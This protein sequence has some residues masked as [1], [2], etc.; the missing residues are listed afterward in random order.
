M[1]D[2]TVQNSQRF[3]WPVC[4]AF[5]GL[6]VVLLYIRTLSYGFATEPDACSA[7]DAQWPD[8]TAVSRSSEQL[9]LL[10]FV[11]PRCSCT[12]A[13][14]QELS[15]VLSRTKQLPAVRVIASCPR[16]A[17]REW[18]ES[19]IVA[20]A[21]ALPNAALIDD[22]WGA[23]SARFGAVVSGTVIVFSQGGS[24]LFS[25]GVT[26]S[27]GHTG[28]STGGQMLLAVL[29][30]EAARQQ[31]AAPVFGC[32]LCLPTEGRRSPRSVRRSGSPGIPEPAGLSITET[33]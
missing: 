17:T 29:N 33:Q 4:I 30:G 23:E 1:S 7:E 26:S 20:D 18:R 11:H 2:T 21:A 3:V 9:T 15:R 28:V 5:W 8:G 31:A 13:S 25:G 22:A 19:S 6:A 27:R 16:N 24:R 10:L 12:R 32:R 14:V